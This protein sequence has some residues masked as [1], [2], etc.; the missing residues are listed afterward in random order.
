MLARAGA[1]L[2]RVVVGFFVGV[3][4]GEEDFAGRLVS[5][6]EGDGWFQVSQLDLGVEGEP[7]NLI[8]SPSLTR[9]K[10]RNMRLVPLHL[11]Q[12]LHILPYFE[13]RL[14]QKPFLKLLRFFDLDGVFIVTGFVRFCVQNILGF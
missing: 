11:M 7:L 3:G 5:E 1:E 13:I 4:A 2:V 14:E 12:E 6:L 10:L 9:I 8:K